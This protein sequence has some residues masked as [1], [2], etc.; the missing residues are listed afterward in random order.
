MT[1][2][3][4]APPKNPKSAGSMVLYKLAEEISNLGYEAARITL[5]QRKD[6]LFFISADEKNYV[7]LE[8]DTLEKII[9]PQNSII[10]H[11]ENLHH[12]FFDKFS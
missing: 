12:K 1:I 6:G 2:I 4:I 9:N 10:I 7:P 3:V 5:A 11:G 8:P